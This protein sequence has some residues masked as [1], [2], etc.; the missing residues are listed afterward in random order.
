MENLE[1]H[2]GKVTTRGHMQRVGAL[3]AAPGLVLLGGFLLLPM[4]GLAVLAFASRGDYGSIEWTFSLTNLQR[5]A[6]YGLF[7]WTADNLTILIRS[8]VIAV[9]TTLACLALALPMSFWIAARGRHGRLVLLA[10]VMVPSCTNLVVRTF[11]WMLALSPNQ[12][13]S[14][15]FQW[16]GLLNEGQGLYPGSLGVYL[17]MVSAMLPF[18]LLPVYASVERLEWA[19]VEAARDLRAGAWRTFRHA[20]LPQ[21]I[22]GMVAAT[23]LTLVPTLGMFVVS[24]LLGGAR[25]MLV[26]N[27]IQQQFGAA[28][29]WSFGAM[30][31]L[32]L[33]IA[34]LLSLLAL[35][36]NAKL[37]VGGGQ[38]P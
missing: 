16:M 32:F 13:P 19:L 6:G 3:L 34:S 37:L 25:Y 1:V 10:L 29:D 31:G 2:E 21:L 15:L 18:A 22:P 35:G 33:V 30:V 28:S 12:P 20:V 5:L 14:Q 27:L 36:K 17:G 38:A 24:D 9:V 11:A 26:G 8:S 7:G 23:V 4:V